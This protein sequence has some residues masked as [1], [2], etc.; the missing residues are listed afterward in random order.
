MLFQNNNQYK[1][2]EAKQK[3]TETQ[4]KIKSARV[5]A[6]HTLKVLKLFSP[7]VFDS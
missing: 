3:K 5:E 7:L 4:T 2:N 1:K 6:S